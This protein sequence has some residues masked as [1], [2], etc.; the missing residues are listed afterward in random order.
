[1]Y[2]KK[3][4]KN[5]FLRL[6]RIFAFACLV[7]T[8]FL[9]Q[10]E[11]AKAA[12]S[13]KV[14]YNGKTVTNTSKKY[15]VI[16]NGKTVSKS[17]FKAIKINKIY[18][19]SYADILKNGVKA[20]CD[21]SSSTKKLTIKYNENTLEMKVG[22]T[23]ATLNDK[24]LTLAQAPLS[25]K[26]VDKGKTKILVPASAVVKAL[27]MTYCKTS[28][29]M[30][31]KD[32]LSIKYNDTDVT[33]N[34][35]QGDI[36][37][38]HTKYAL[39][40][41]PVIKISQKY[42]APVQEVFEKILGWDYSQSSNGE[43]KLDNE[44][45]EISITAAVGSD[46]I[47][48]NGQEV[49]MGNT[50][51]NILDKKT[52]T[53]VICAPI[54]AI[55]KAAGYKREWESAGNYY[56]IQSQNFFDWKKVLTN[57]QISNTAANYIYEMSSEYSINKQ[58]GMIKLRV[59]GSSKDIMEKLTIKR[60]K[61]KITI[62]IPTSTY[63]LNSNHFLNF[64]EIMEKME[65]TSVD[66]SVVITATCKETEEYSYTVT[67]G[68][69][70]LNILHTYS[71]IDSIFSD[72]SL[73]IQ[74]PDA[75]KKSDISNTDMYPN[76]KGFKIILKGNY[77]NEL[78]KNPVVINHNSAKSVTT[79]KNSSGNTVIKV[80][81]SSVL[82]YKI[83]VKGDYIVV[84][85]A[86]PK[87][88]YKSIVVLDAGH[89]GYDPG[90]QNKGKNEKDLN[91]KILYTLMKNYFTDNAPDIK[92]YWTRTTDT[93][94]TLADRAAFAKK[95][96]ADVFISLHM[97]SASSSS[98]NGTEVYYSVSNNKKDFSGLTS[99]AMAALF[100]NQLIT[101]LSTKNRGTKTAAYYVLKH[102]TVP[103]ILIELGFISGSSDY[104]KLTSSSFQKKAAESIYKGIV[105][106]FEKYPT[107]R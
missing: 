44:D 51:Y 85:M 81:T 97:N 58:T 49:S 11:Q 30:I 101:D 54:A 100:K 96:D 73:I 46:K 17:G 77:V 38:N 18:M 50:V 63:L 66:G 8:L 24:K 72:Y 40:T 78:K 31:I 95:V 15:P 90:A 99:K 20:E 2:T 48:V 41:M 57:E 68:V 76:S 53:S 106:L 29:E 3:R 16:Y 75:I 89:G 83:Y 94:V 61:N 42:Y 14:R 82:G 43:I 69:L 45:L 64:G 91:F 103:S 6:F 60:E 34:N 5:N 27:G 7:G 4:K 21:Y 107:N 19:I 55:L 9:C 88:I 56:S 93:F 22:S 92:V 52:N 10:N 104:S 65:V 37:Y 25:V 84:K 12:E 39:T 86:K 23:S 59:T 67:D 35:V 1:M 70:E 26:Y 80:K 102:N 47:K 87:K 62:T 74:K 33:Y 32:G 79:T 28:D 36:Y 105:S 71:E 13:V 98:A